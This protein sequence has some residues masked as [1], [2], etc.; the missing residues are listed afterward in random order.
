MPGFD[1][2]STDIKMVSG[3]IAIV[4]GGKGCQALEGIF[5][6]FKRNCDSDNPWQGF[7]LSSLF[8]K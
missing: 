4:T 7:C 3:E 2:K 6:L 8:R 1:V 5:L